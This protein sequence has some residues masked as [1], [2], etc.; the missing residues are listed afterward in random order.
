MAPPWRPRREPRSPRRDTGQRPV[1]FLGGLNCVTLGAECAFRRASNSRASC[2]TTLHSP[3]AVAPL[4]ASARATSTGSLN[5]ATSFLR[6]H[7]SNDLASLTD[8]VVACGDSLFWLLSAGSGES[9]R[10]RVPSAPQQ[11]NEESQPAEAG[12]L[13]FRSS[14]LL[15]GH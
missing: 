2:A 12:F 10:I 11:T 1:S 6:S 14:Q 5:P 8:A 3:A 13:V 7:D 4:I 9:E 15:V